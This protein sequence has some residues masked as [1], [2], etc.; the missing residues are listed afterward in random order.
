MLS[1]DKEI[2]ETNRPQDINL[3]SIF[4]E[5]IQAAGMACESNASD[6][7]YDIEEISEAVK[8]CEEKTIYL[9]FRN[10]GVDGN[11]FIKSRFEQNKHYEYIKMYKVEIKPSEKYDDYIQ[12]TL[13][14]ISNYGVREEMGIK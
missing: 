7:L 3:S 9:G 8:N 6:I 14:R 13:T 12:V 5:L 2:K 11:S 4:S 10:M 1:I